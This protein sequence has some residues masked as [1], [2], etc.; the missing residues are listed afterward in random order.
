MRGGIAAALG[1]PVR[2]SITGTFTKTAAPSGGIVTSDTITLTVPAGS[3]GLLDVSG[4]VDTG[5]VNLEFQRNAG[6]YTGGI[7]AGAAVNNDTMNARITG[8]TAGESSSFSIVESATGRVV[9]GPYT[10]TAS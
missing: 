5:T 8:A 7:P 1:Y 9:G 6:G 10:I 4:Q 3:D 2:M